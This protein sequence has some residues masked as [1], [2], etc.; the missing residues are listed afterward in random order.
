MGLREFKVDLHIHTCLSP[1]ADLTMIPS[2]L[3]KEAKKK[4]LDGIGICDHNSAENVAAVKKIGERDGLKVFGGIEI[5]SREEAHILAY[6]DDDESLLQMQKTIYNNLSGENDASYFGEQLVAD[7]N[8]KFIESNDRLLIGST[9]LPVSKI[10]QLT[11]N[12]GG[13]AVAAHIDRESFSLIGQ[14]G[15]IPEGLPL[16]ALEVSYQY[17]QNKNIDIRSFDLPLLTSSDAHHPSD[18]GRSFT[19]FFLSELS[20]SEMVMAFQGVKGR[21]VTI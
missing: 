8:D 20:F 15:F 7:E 4:N 12:L 6:F 18:I 21:K 17:K 9:D 16:D 19:T 2:A 13:V 5:S 11:H 10:V 1:C 3:I 14:L